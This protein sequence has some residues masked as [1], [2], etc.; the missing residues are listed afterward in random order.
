MTEAEL[1]ERLVKVEERAKS[2]TH[3]IEE[4]KPIVEEI[5]TMSKTMIELTSECRHTNETVVDL[6]NDVSKLNT[7]VEIIEKEPA[8]EWKSV[9][10]IISTALISAVIG[11]IVTY[12]LTHFGMVL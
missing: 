8:N 9:K 2:N 5:H 6:K 12:V 3:Q 10:K 4:L 7:K 11:A 1:A